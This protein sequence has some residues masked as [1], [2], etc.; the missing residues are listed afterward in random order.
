MRENESGT[1][2][3]MPKA[4]ISDENK[5]ILDDEYDRP[6]SSEHQAAYNEWVQYCQIVKQSMH[7]PKVFKAEGLVAIGT[8]KFGIVQER[9]CD[10]EASHPFKKCNLADFIDGKGYFDLVKF[11]GFNR[12]SFPFI[13]RLACC[14]AAMRMNE[15]GCERFFSV[16]GY[17]SNPRRTRLK[18]RHYEA[19]A[20]L[21]QNMQRIYID[22]DWVVEQY[23]TKE[24]DKG[25]DTMDEQN[26]QLV[27]ALEAELYANDL[28]IS[29]EALSSEESEE[30]VT[31]HEIE[32][33]EVPGSTGSSDDES[34]SSSDG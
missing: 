32:A 9:G 24:K 21:K 1:R 28:G 4:V 15:V 12:Q 20:M 5:D 6:I 31:G 23:M 8:I 25:W 34:D 27:A 18:V 7:F 11:I 3:L 14:L 17:V 30:E 2:S 16:A 26:D 13:Y 29:V 10:M 19:L 33:P 22:E